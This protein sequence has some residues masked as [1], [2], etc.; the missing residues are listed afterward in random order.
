MLV[1]FLVEFGYRR[2]MIKSSCAMI[3]ILV[4]KR[5]FELRDWYNEMNSSMCRYVDF[6]Y[7]IID[8]FKYFERVGSLIDEF[9]IWDFR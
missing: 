5:R 9:E 6:V 3:R 1:S 2:R 7:Q 8:F 4:F